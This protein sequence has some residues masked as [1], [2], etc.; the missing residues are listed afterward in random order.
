MVSW[1]EWGPVVARKSSRDEEEKGARVS[2]S[3]S[4]PTSKKNTLLGRSEE[5]FPKKDRLLKRSEFIRVQRKGRK[6]GTKSL[7]ILYQPGKKGRLRLGIAA[8]KKIGNSVVRN[9]IKRLIREVFRKNRK[10]F[11]ISADIVV[12]PKRVEHRICYHSLVEELKLLAWRK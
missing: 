1:P 2:Q 7:I 12:I 8:S 10:L 4:Q 6:H 5:A 3:S 11:P 9:R